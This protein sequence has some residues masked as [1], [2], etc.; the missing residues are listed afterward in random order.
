MKDT[1]DEFEVIYVTNGKKKFPY[2]KHIEDAET[3][4][5]ITCIQAVTCQS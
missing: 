5:S 2:N 3:W 4:F 1:S